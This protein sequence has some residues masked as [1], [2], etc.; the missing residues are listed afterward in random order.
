M[1]RSERDRRIAELLALVGLSGIGERAARRLSGGEQQRLALARA[2]A[3]EPEILFLDEP[4]ARLDPAATKAVEDIIAQVAARGIKIVMST[5]DLGRGETA[6]RRDRAAPSRPR[7]RNRPRRR[8]FHRAQ[9][10]RRAPL[11]RGRTAD[12]KTA[13]NR[14]TH[15]D[16]DT[17]HASRPCRA[18]PSCDARACAGQIHRR[19]LDDLDAGFR[20][21]RPYP[22]A[23]QGRRPAST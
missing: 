21:V 22:A 7:R 5:H 17:P 19:R 18:R 14:E 3:K 6:R 11:R 20:P 23:V 1:P 13:R 4:T 12:L 15:H 16:S 10:G 2:L 9:N 8:F